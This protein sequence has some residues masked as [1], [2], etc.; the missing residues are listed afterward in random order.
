M[1]SGVRSGACTAACKSLPRPQ[2]PMQ[3]FK[4]MGTLPNSLEMRRVFF[5][6]QR[7]LTQ[8]LRRRGVLA[9]CFEVGNY[10]QVAI[11][12]IATAGASEAGPSHTCVCVPIPQDSMSTEHRVVLLRLE[13]T[14]YPK[15]PSAD[16]SE[17][18]IEACTI[19]TTIPCGLL[20]H[21]HKIY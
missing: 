3:S 7:F 17:T 15:Q 8:Y 2:S 20:L 14:F 11:P 4:P 6:P 9:R 16:R 18:T 12:N 21:L 19:S 1:Q 10:K 13:Q 5:Q